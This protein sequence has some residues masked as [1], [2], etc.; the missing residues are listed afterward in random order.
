MD[1][2][3]LKAKKGLTFIKSKMLRIIA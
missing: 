3:R 1:H 2:G